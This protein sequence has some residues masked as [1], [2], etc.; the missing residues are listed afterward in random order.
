M[1]ST[2]S[3]SDKAS[4]RPDTRDSQMAPIRLANLKDQIWHSCAEMYR[5]AVARLRQHGCHE[6]LQS[7]PAVCKAHT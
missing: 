4:R 7:R 3:C 5:A 6:E 2:E 1:S